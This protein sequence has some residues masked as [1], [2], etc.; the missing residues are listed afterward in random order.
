MLASPALFPAFGDIPW[1]SEAG[2]GG[3]ISLR[4]VTNES[5]IPLPAPRITN[6]DAVGN[7]SAGLYTS[8]EEV[9]AASPDEAVAD[10]ELIPET[11]DEIEPVEASE[12]EPDRGAPDPAPE[13]DATARASATP[14]E[15]AAPAP[16]NA[17]PFGAGGQ[18]DIGASYST[19]GGT[20]GVDVGDGTFGRQFGRY[21]NAMRRRISE[22]WYQSMV[23]ANVRSGE[24]VTL[25][26]EILRN[27]MIQDVRIIESS[28]VRSLDD[29]AE[30]ALYRVRQLE[31]LPPAYRGASIDVQFWFEFTR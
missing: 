21:V 31:V 29:S 13:T 1:G 24:R 7:D 11:F 16:D 8:V 10:A 18:P 5:G 22:N 17:V 30:R 12:S 2:S 3:A 26:F 15:D 9:V 19:T 23:D 25:E 14:A 4:L 6:P 20:Y 28:G 27:G